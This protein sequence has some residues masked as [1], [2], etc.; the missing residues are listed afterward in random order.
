MLHFEDL[1]GLNGKQKT[2]FRIIC[3][4]F[5]NKHVLKKEDLPPLSMVMTGPGGTGKTYVINAVKA[6]MSHY[7]CAHQIRYLAPTGS[8]ASLIDGMT[9]H[10]GLGIK[11]KVNRNG[12]SNRQ[13]GESSEDYTVLISVQ[14]RTQLRDEW[15]FVEIVFI[16]E[17]SML[18]LQLLCE[19][20]HAL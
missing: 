2:C 7:G 11:I 16:D 12:K 4:W 13:L 10:K 8:A 19:M 17:S 3:E 14:S 5:I 1:Y 9:I 6:V 18:S 15:R 20:D